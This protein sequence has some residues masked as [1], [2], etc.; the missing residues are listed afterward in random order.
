MLRSRV[1][2]VLLIK[3]KGL[4]KSIKFSD[5]KYLGDPINAV[6]IFNEKRVDELMMIDIDATSKSESPRTTFSATLRLP[7]SINSW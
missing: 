1:I 2:P 6:R 7:T 4:V 5:Y 3:D